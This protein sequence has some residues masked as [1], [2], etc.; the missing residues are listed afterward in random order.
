[1][2]FFDLFRPTKSSNAAKAAVAIQWLNKLGHVERLSKSQI[3]CL[4]TNLPD[5]QKHLDARQYMFVKSVFD[6]YRQETTLIPLDMFK[7]VKVCKEIIS[8]YET[9]VPYFLFD[10]SYSEHLTSKDIDD[11]WLLYDKGLR[12]DEM[13]ELIF[14]GFVGKKA[15]E[16]RN[17]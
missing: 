15:D 12:Y 13:E 17:N 7:Y 16:L 2:S 4:I 5:A 10:G 3:V 9:S 14:R 11:V 8:A 6:L 1:M